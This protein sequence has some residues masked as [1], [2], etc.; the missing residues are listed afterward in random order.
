MQDAKAKKA[1]PVELEDVSTSSKFT[2]RADDKVNGSPRLDDE[3]AKSIRVAMRNKQA[4]MGPA[5]PPNHPLSHPVSRPSTFWV[6]QQISNAESAKKEKELEAAK[7]RKSSPESP[8][9]KP[10]I[11][12]YW[13]SAMKLIAF[14]LHSKHVPFMKVWVILAKVALRPQLIHFPLK[15]TGKL[16]LH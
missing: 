4:P 13:G 11:L 7:L 6:N 14:K 15:F 10:F 16:L 12:F 1:K 9:G 5:M 3:N 8:D 2:P